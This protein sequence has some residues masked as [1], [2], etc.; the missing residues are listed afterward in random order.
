MRQ[1]SNYLERSD[2]SINRDH[3]YTDD[4]QLMTES[5]TLGVPSG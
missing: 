1:H 5:P 4:K 3:T 2:C